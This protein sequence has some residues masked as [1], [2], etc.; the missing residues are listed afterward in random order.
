ML[1]SSFIRLSSLL[2]C[3]QSPYLLC[4]TGPFSCADG[5]ALSLTTSYRTE[6]LPHPC[7]SV[8][9]GGINCFLLLSCIHNIQ[10]LSLP[11]VLSC[12]KIFCSEGLARQRHHKNCIQLLS[13]FLLHWYVKCFWGRSSEWMQYNRLGMSHS[14]FSHRTLQDLLT[15]IDTTCTVT[16]LS[17]YRLWKPCLL[18]WLCKN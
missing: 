3:P 9:L 13:V 8:L 16:V 4:H 18:S 15:S 1:I 6:T 17:R 12:R 10:F 5:W 14:V 7:L 11:V 2:M